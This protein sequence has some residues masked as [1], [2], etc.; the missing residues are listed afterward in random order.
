MDWNTVIPRFAGLLPPESTTGSNHVE[1]RYFQR[2]FARLTAA[3]TT[4][5]S[6]SQTHGC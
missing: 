1:C 2:S 3:Q 6:Q 4:R 5:F